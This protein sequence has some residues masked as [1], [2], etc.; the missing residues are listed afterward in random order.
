MKDLCKKYNIP[1]TAYGFFSNK[2]EELAYKAVDLI[3][4]PE[5]FCRRD[6]GWQAV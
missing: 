6:I 3:E 2:Q 5:G 1:T 4:W